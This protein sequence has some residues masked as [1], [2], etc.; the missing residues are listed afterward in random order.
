MIQL[1]QDL[2]Q[3]AISTSEAD[4]KEAQEDSFNRVTIKINYQLGEKIIYFSKDY[5]LVWEY[6]SETGYALADPE[7]LRSFAESIT[8]GVRREETSGKPFASMDAPWDWCKNVGIDALESVQARICVADYS[9]GNSS[10]S[11]S[12]MGAI[13][14]NTLQEML[15]ILNQI[16]KDAFT[17]GRTISSEN[18]GML[19]SVMGA[20]TCKIAIIDG[21]NNLAAVFIHKDGKTE[22]VMTDEMEKV[23]NDSPTYLQPMQT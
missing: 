22:I 7:P 19:T 17:P 12:S 2:K 14:R 18:Y 13:S 4:L 8:D 16:P 11:T 10:G 9:S 5:R 3:Q 23:R 1:L 15:S 21:V 20:G 6:G